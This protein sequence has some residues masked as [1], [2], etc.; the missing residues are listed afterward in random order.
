[1]NYP[2]LRTT[3]TESTYKSGKPTTEKVE[4]SFSFSP[5]IIR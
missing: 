5:F 1:M 2:K 3:L 4:T